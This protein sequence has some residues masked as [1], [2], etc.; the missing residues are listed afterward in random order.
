MRKRLIRWLLVSACSGVVFGFAGTWRDPWLWTYAVVWSALVL[1]AMFS[2]D[3]DLAQERF[4]P[5][6]AGADRVALHWV[7]A[8]ALTHIVVG[9]LDT[10]RWHLTAPVPPLFRAFALA[11]IAVAFGMFFRAMREN[12]F[13]SS[14]VR[15]QSDRGHRVVDTGPYAVVRHPGYA[16]M[17]VGMPLSG[18][19]LG[20]WVASAIGVALSLLFIR[21][22]L[23]EDGFLK[24]NL[25][26][27]ASYANRV[28]YRLIPCVW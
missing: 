15:V 28:K 25:K 11:G 16:G 23:F 26:G 12:R 27:Y 18:L 17:I 22:V 21:R 10:G 24:E 5:P 14:V 2:I 19:A 20:S 4:H 13:F 9:A 8:L 3:E 7:R 1:Y 6:T